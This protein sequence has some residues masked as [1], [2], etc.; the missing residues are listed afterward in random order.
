MKD[1]MGKRI[2]RKERSEKGHPGKEMGPDGGSESRIRRVGQA[3]AERT[4]IL[5]RATFEGHSTQKRKLQG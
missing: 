4:L 3:L 5:T 1:W 2:K